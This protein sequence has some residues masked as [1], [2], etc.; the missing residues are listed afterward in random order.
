MSW[1]VPGSVL[2]AVAALGIAQPCAAQQESSARQYPALFGG[3]VGNI[4]QSL[5]FAASLGGGYEGNVAAASTGQSV[6][7]TTAN[8]PASRVASTNG[9]LSYTLNGNK[10][11]L[12]AQGGGWATYYPALSTSYMSGGNGAASLSW[13]PLAGSSFSLSESVA[14]QPLYL[15]L[16]VA[17][18]EVL[19]LPVNVAPSD[20]TTAQF[21]NQLRSQTGLS[22]TQKISTRFSAFV[23]GGVAQASSPS[24]RLVPSLSS[25]EAT[26]GLSYKVSKDLA[27]RVA[28]FDDEARFDFNGI[29]TTGII[30]GVDGGVDFSKALSLTRKTRLNFGVD[31]GTLSEGNQT[32]FRLNGNIGLTRDIGRSWTATANVSRA[33]DF[34]PTFVR[35][36]L[37]DALGLN[38]GGYLSRRLKL[39]T[40]VGVSRGSVGLT[41]TANTFASGFATTTA[42]FGITKSLGL[43]ADYVYARYNFGS[44]VTLPTGVSRLLSRQSVRVTLDFW[45][46]LLRVVRSPDNVAR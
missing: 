46:P 44:G 11:G 20:A 26:A 17:G 7:A 10:V 27:V 36:V 2:A 43:S 12:S 25:S 23:I 33:A 41:G 39:T 13:T 14:N 6:D 5:T 42:T 18:S 31:T 22:Y 28:Y 3:G 30:R 21:G 34:E 35:P 38:L 19:N 40:G 4:A 8:A 45:V 16:P 15:V 29:H 24:D 1:R 32:S 37:Y 9:T